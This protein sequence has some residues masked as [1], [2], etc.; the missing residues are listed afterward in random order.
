MSIA[1]LALLDVNRIKSFI[2]A[3]PY[4]REIRGSSRLL[5]Q[6]N[7]RD[8]VKKSLDKRHGTLLYAGGGSVLA[9]FPSKH[10][11][12]QFIRAEHQRLEEKTRG[13]ATLTGISCEIGAD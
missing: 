5:A 7:D 2:L 1:S 9:R 6:F 4:L 11:A 10:E 8:Q 3:A 13:G 12:D